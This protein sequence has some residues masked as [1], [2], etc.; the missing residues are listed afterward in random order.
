MTNVSVVAAAVLALTP[1]ATYSQ[2]QE[3]HHDTPTENL[4]TVHFANSCDPK[5]APQFDRA[6]ALLHS[7]EF[8]ASIRGFNDVLAADS[9]CAIAYWGIA[10]SRWTNPMAPGNRPVA[11]LQQGKQAVNAAGRLSGAA[12]ERERGYINAVGQ[13][14]DDYE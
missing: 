3:H 9:T 1:F 14:Y 13:L 5:V 4:G 7:F 11:L 2:V 8:G 10:L 12:S 6:V